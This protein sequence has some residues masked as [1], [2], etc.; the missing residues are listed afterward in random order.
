MY[1]EPDDFAAEGNRE[2]EL[3]LQASWLTSESGVA[4]PAMVAAAKHEL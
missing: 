4:I 3:C 1:E 2:V